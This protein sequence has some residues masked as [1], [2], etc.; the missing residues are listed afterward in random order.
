MANLLLTLF[1]VFMSVVF[2]VYSLVPKKC[3]YIVLLVF[4]LAFFA[5]YSKFMIAFLFATIISIYFTGIWLN[6][7]NDKQSS[8][9][10]TIED[11]EQ[12][13]TIKKQFTKKKKGVLALAVIFNVAIL[14]VLKYSGFFANIFEGV[15]GWFNLSIELPVL[16]L[17]LPLGISYYTLSAIGYVIDVYRGKYRGDTNF[18]KVALFVSYF[19]Q[20]WEGPFARYNELAPQLYAGADFDSKRVCKGITLILWG[21][22]LKFCALTL[23]SC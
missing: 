15:F 22:F 13:K 17:L 16:K 10:S 6:K 3:K 5:I 19:P 20:L 11:K 21:L 14:A 18:C 8:I 2:V 23:F 12:K 9:V 1:F 7:I 4:S